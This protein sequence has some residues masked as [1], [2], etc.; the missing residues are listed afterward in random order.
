MGNGVASHKEGS[1]YQA[2]LRAVCLYEYSFSLYNPTTHIGELIIDVS[3]KK[4]L[5]FTVL[6]EYVVTT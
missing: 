2:C 3:C 1:W 4:C 5:K 6:Y